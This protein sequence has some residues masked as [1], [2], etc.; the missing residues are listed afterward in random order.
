MGCSP[1][2]HQ[3]LM[4]R[5]DGNVNLL[6]QMVKL[7][8]KVSPVLIMRIEDGILRHDVEQVRHAAHNL[9]GMVSNFASSAIVD[10][11]QTIESIGESKDFS[12]AD[13]LIQALKNQ[14]DDLSQALQEIKHNNSCAVSL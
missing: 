13:A 14:W 8:F 1:I 5:V 10:T 4:N 2:N 3:E 12:N 6:D 7:F 9:K 11:I